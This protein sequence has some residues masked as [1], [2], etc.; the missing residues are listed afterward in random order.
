MKRNLITTAI[1]LIKA[2]LIFLSLLHY[3]Y[4][5]WL[6]TVNS[7][8]MN[9]AVAEENLLANEQPDMVSESTLVSINEI[10]VSLVVYLYLHY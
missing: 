5:Q 6:L 4:F 7:L 1:I 10:P 3:N 8:W 2:F 9:A